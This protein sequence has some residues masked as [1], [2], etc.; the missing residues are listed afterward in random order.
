MTVPASARFLVTGS[1]GF[2]GRR[3][4]RRLVETFGARSVVCLVHR[5]QT[6]REAAALASQRAQGVRVIEGDLLDDPVSREQPP[7]VEVVFHLAANI[8][9]DAS[10]E[11][12]LVNHEGTSHLLD[13]LRPVSPNVRIVY[14]SSVAVHDRDRSPT[15]PI[16]EDSPLV[17]RTAYGRTKLLGET[18]LRDRAADGGYS[19]TTVRLPTVYGPDQKPGGLFDKLITPASKGAL[20]GCND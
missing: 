18:I 17:S 20:L 14:A 6:P 2:I 4:V 7:P 8:D 3:L 5:R 12:L 16:T 9:T 15:A 19:W 13:W 10:E 11:E 1:T